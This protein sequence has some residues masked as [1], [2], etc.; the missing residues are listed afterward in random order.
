MTSSMSYARIHNTFITQETT[1]EHFFISME[2]K[3]IFTW[4]KNVNHLVRFE[5]VLSV[6]KFFTV[7]IIVA[8][9]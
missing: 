8:V 4:I 1:S 5:T 7:K 6:T 9:T 3:A 2:P